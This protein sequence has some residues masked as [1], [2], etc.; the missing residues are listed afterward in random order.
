MIRTSS[1][2][3]RPTPPGAPGTSATLRDALPPFVVLY[4]RYLDERIREYTYALPVRCRRSACLPPVPVKPNSS[5]LGQGRLRT[6][7]IA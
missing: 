2:P 4:R 1:G 7:P 6:R 3:P 5:S